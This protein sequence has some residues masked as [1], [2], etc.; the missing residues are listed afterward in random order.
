MVRLVRQAV[1]A[2]LVLAGFWAFYE[3]TP[4]ENLAR[5]QRTQQNPVPMEQ[6]QM[7][8]FGH[9]STTDHLAPK[10]QAN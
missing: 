10:T 7:T 5:L 9:K 4:A 1:F 3:L 2:V 6:A 8:E